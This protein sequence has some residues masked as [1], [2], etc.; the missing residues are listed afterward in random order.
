MPLSSAIVAGPQVGRNHSLAVR[1]LPRRLLN[2]L[3]QA[4]LRNVMLGHLRPRVPH[5]EAE[6]LQ[7]DTIF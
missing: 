7:V 1:D 3:R 4:R 2:L 5:A 6:K